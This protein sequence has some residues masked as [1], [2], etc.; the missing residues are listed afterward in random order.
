MGRAAW[1]ARHDLVTLDLRNAPLAEAVRAIEHQTWERVAVDSQLNAR[2]TIHVEN[3][4]L[5]H[6]LDLLAAKA[7][8]R[9]RKTYAVCDSRIALARL[10]SAVAGGEKLDMAGWTNLAPDISEAAFPDAPASARFGSGGSGQKGFGVRGFGT[11]GGNARMITTLP[12]GTVDRWSSERLVM[13][14]GLAPKLAGPPPLEA[15]EETAS[16]TAAAV[17]ARSSVFYELARAPFAMGGGGR[18]MR[19][20]RNGGG[21]GPGKIGDVAAEMTNARRQQRLRDLSDSPEAQVERARQHGGG[22][23][24]IQ[25]VED[26]K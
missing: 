3:A 9:W 7:G 12:D 10:E 22:K 13:E 14:S 19:F 21:G 11:G 18:R 2:V 6:V 26:S 1:R 24:Q 23:I 4:P 5:A 8:A 16:Q 20:S 17:H 25:N 15:N